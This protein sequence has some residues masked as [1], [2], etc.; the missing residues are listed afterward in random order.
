MESEWLHALNF[1]ASYAVYK[2]SR[3][4]CVILAM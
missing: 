2:N 4:T 1:D 3:I